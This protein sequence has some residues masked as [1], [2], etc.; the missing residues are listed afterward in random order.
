MTEMDFEATVR[1]IATRIDGLAACFIAH[2]VSGFLSRM[3]KLR[4]VLFTAEGEP[5]L[6]R[7]KRR[8]H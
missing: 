5:D 4:E 7:E 8:P 1:T 6:S 3:P 2:S